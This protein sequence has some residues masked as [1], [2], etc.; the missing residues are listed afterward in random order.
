[1]KCIQTLWS[2]VQP[3]QMLTTN[4]WCLLHELPTL[5]N[6]N[7]GKSNARVMQ[8]LFACKHFKNT[9]LFTTNRAAWRC[10]SFFFVSG[11][12]RDHFLCFYLNLFWTFNEKFHDYNPRCKWRNA[13]K[14]HEIAYYT[15]SNRSDW[16]FSLRDYKKLTVDSSDYRLWVNSTLNMSSII[17]QHNH[18]FRYWVCTLNS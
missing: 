7:G 17:S 5:S 10:I 2:L 18:V 9:N 1:M 13:P 12:T 16:L 8:L 11:N 4:L 14:R 3:F 6:C 15:I